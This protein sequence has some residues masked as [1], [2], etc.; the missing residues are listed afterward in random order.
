MIFS[1]H[2]GLDAQRIAATAGRNPRPR[3]RLAPLNGNE[4]GAARA[5]RQTLYF[6]APSWERKPPAAAV[7]RVTPGCDLSVP[8]MKKYPRDSPAHSM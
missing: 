3:R 5:L 6:C 4:N 8:I 1:C 7:S 2:N